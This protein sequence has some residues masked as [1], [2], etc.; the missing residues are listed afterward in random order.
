LNLVVNAHDAM[1]QGGTL[2]I[3]TTNVQVRADDAATHPGVP[4]GPYVRLAVT[5]SGSG[6]T[7]TVK[8]HLFEPFFT[9]KGPGKG[10]GLG[11]A[12]VHGVVEQSDGHTV[13]LSEEGVGTKFH[14]Y[15]PR[16]GGPPSAVEV[17]YDWSA[18]LP[19]GS[20]TVLIVEDE[21][22]VRALARLI[23]EQCGYRVL[24]AGDVD[25]AM[26]LVGGEQAPIHLL[27]VD[28]VMPG[29]GGRLLTE[30]LRA[31]HPEIKVLFISGYA[32]DAIVRHGIL[33]DH[34]NFLQKPFAPRALALK[35]REVLATE[36]H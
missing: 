11:L 21:P 20:E 27:V 10:T 8:R 6:M 22:G 30:Q 31:S 32:D 24:E 35:V 19:Q 18:V 2:T 12:V 4:A 13:V 1:P 9:T 7:E 14:I 5:D 29:G 28:V 26:R 34:V 3:E 25:E 16:L 17:T 15:F 36:G 33:H 23:L